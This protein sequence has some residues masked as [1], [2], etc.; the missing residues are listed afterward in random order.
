MP[1]LSTVAAFGFDEFN[2]STLLPLY[3]ELGCTGSQFYRNTDN[4]P[5]TSEARRIAQD[6]GV[7]FDSIHGVFGPQYDPSSLDDSVRKATIE[8][9]RREGDLALEL[10]GPCIVVH[11]SPHADDPKNVTQ[12]HRDQRIDPLRRSMEELAGIGHHLGVTYLFENI[13][14]PAY[15][16]H[17][18]AQLASLIRELNHPNIRMCFDTGHAHMTCSADAAIEGCGDV[19]AYLHVH[20]NDSIKDSHQIPGQGTYPWKAARR[21]MVA[22]PPQVPAMLELFESEQTLQRHINDGLGQKLAG[23]LAIDHCGKT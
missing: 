12:H 14:F 5:P 10:G 7:P 4:P 11:P 23:W 9:Y 8:T 22:L 21:T 18:P 1:Y 16:G 19:I 13:P 6:A 17:D 3:H 15:L 20:D 2:P